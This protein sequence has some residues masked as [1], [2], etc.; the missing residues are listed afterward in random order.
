[1][2]ATTSHGG[3]AAISPLYRL[4]ASVIKN[5][6][7]SER[8]AAALELYDTVV[9]PM[10]LNEDR[11]FLAGLPDKHRIT[12]F[13]NAGCALTCPS[14]TCYASVSKMNKGQGGQFLCSQPVKARDL[15][16]MIDFDLRPLQD[17]GFSRFK[18]LRS[19]PSGMTGY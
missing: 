2:L 4:E 3:S 13:A 18:L 8:I 19:R 14:R 7:T 10:E 12:L 11:E 16:G 5:L 6:K 1:M 17:L 9:L 15:R